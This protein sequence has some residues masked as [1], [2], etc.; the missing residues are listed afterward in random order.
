MIAM[1]F[2][3]HTEIDSKKLKEMIRFC[4][5]NGVTNY[6]IV[7][8]HRN[9]NGGGISA[10]AWGCSYRIVVRIGHSRY[11]RIVNNC[12]KGYIPHLVLDLDEHLVGVIAHEL[13]HLWQS[14]YRK[15]HR[16][17]GSRGVFS[18]R[19]ADAYCIRKIREWRKDAINS[20]SL[21]DFNRLLSLI[22][23]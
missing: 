10:N 11:P 5:P 22:R 16:V 2:E 23:Q 17:W 14:R 7:F 3:N 19:D 20:R 1:K 18:E 21:F 13:R 6:R 8:K 4:K 15:G 9:S 12:G